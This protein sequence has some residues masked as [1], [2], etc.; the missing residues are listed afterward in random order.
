[1]KHQ[2]IILLADAVSATDALNRQSGDNRYYTN[3]TTLNNITPPL[4]AVSMNGH[5]ITNL[6]PATLNTDAL[7]LQTADSRYY[8]NSTTLD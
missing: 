3:T 6:G 4:S 2:K 8:L 7:N 5:K 1:M